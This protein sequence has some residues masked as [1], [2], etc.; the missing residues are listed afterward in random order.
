MILTALDRVGCAT[1]QPAQPSPPSPARL[2][3]P[4]H[5]YHH[6][7]AAAVPV[8][9]GGAG[10]VRAR[11]PAQHVALALELLQGLGSQSHPGFDAL[12]PV[13]LRPVRWSSARRARFPAV[14]MTTQQP[15][16]CCHGVCCRLEASTGQL[17]P[18][19][20]AFVSCSPCAQPHCL[21]I[22][23]VQLTQRDRSSARQRGPI[24]R[25]PR[26]DRGGGPRGARG[27]RSSPPPPL[28][29]RRLQG[30]Q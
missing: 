20:C 21:S 2:T 19:S 12:P 26:L 27:H 14:T 6:G 28:P 22:R 4:H 1:L 18:S 13:S 25:S 24:A 5:G 7:V 29:P 11:G 3:S 17:R 23:G 8:F 16:E 10:R 30:L 15:G 9:R